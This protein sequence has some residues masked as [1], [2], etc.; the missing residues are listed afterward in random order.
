[1]RQTGADAEGAFVN[2][3]RTRCERSQYLFGKIIMGY[4]L[5]T[6]T[7]HL[8]LCNAMQAPPPWR[9]LLLLPRGHLKTTILKTQALHAVIQPGT[10]RTDGT[11]ENVYFPQ[12]IGA[13]THARGT[14][15][16]ILFASRGAD[17]ARST[18][19]EIM[20][21]AEE[22]QLLKALW[23]SAMW[24]DPRKQARWW[25]QERIVF[26][27]QDHYKE[28]TIETIGVGGQITGY[29][30]N[31]HIFDDL[32]DINDANSPTTMQ[33]A[34]EWWRASR[35]LMDDP[36]RTLEYTVGTRWAV[37]DLYEY[38]IRNDPTVEPIV[39][40]VVEG[41]EPIFPERFS[42]DTVNRLQRELGSMFPLLYMNSATD[43]TLTDFNMDKVRRFWMSDGKVCYDENE[44]DA[45]AIERRQLAAQL[46][47]GLE[48]AAAARAEGREPT[49]KTGRYD[50][51][52]ART[53]YLRRGRHVRF[54]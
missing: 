28:A 44:H 27:R 26:P 39:R 13:L 33:T 6:P 16:R 10:P 52:R 40:R 54:E 24:D 21:A 36:D 11:F 3:L 49:G 17:L 45:L 37:A 7:L 38:I 53:E 41:G 42:I 47:E 23:P 1:M 2:E 12:G 22:N 46:R 50:V 31:M 43:P 32:V 5:L 35:A 9:R 20:V 14:S 51:F 8:P 18:L 34:I 30:F 29:H 25:N 48:A 19:S 15:T 4:D